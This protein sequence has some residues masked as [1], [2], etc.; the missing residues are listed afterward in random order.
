VTI[1][2][3]AEVIELSM[4]AVA[5]IDDGRSAFRLIF[6]RDALVSRLSAEERRLFSLWARQVRPS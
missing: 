6:E 2:R 1:D 4:R 5:A 3:L